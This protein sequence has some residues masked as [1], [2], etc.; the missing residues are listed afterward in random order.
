MTPIVINAIL[1]V[2]GL[3]FAYTAIVS[4]RAPVPFARGLGLEPNGRSGAIEI[5]AQYGGFFAAAGLAQFAVFAGLI[6]P[7]PALF[8]GLVIFGG[9]I[10]GRVAAFFAGGKDEKLLP[11]ISALYWIDGIG[12]L[13]ALIG[14][15]L[16]S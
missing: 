12:C 5:R 7:Q 3:F 1:V 15:F 2:F 10:V 4:F 9:L 11:I 6:S 8:V 14:L 13:A 16:A